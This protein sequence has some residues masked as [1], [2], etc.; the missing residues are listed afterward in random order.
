MHGL[1]GVCRLIRW[2]EKSE[3][4]LCM[5]SRISAFQ[6][7]RWKLS[8]QY[9]AV[10]VSALFVVVLVLG[11]MLVSRV[12]LPLDL[13][14]T[15]LS[16]TAWI[17]IVRND[18]PELLRHI[19]SQ[20]PIDTV[21]ISRFLEEGE[22][23]ITLSD[24]L[25]VGD[26][27][28]QLRTVGQGSSLL[29]DSKGILLGTSNPDI[30]SPN[31]VGEPI[32]PSILPGLEGPL[33]AALRGDLDVDRLFVTLVPDEEF[34]FAVPIHDESGQEVLG[35]VV[36]YIERLPTEN[37]Y[38]SNTLAL[39]GRSALVLLFSTGLAGM[40]F[41]FLTAKGITR[42][43]QHAS[44][45]TDAWSRGDFSTF[46][47]DTVNDEIGNLG[48]RLNRM[49]LQLKELLK[50][51]E[52]IAVIEERN[53]LARDL[54]D[55]AKQQALAA[56]FQIGTALTLYERE[57]ETAK[58]HLE[59]A[60]RLVDRVREEL[61]DLIMELRPQALEQRSIEEILSEYLTDWST[62]HAFE[63]EQALQRDIP[64]SVNAKQTLLRILQEALANIARHSEGSQVSIKLHAQGDEVNLE[65]K[66]NGVGFNPEKVTRGVGIQ[67][68]R[69][70]TESLGGSL[71][72]TSTPEQGTTLIAR[73]P[74]LDKR[75]GS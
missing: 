31:L 37:D 74:I 13:L 8:L 67:S 18:Y 75:E 56:S 64:L 60:E 19:L 14:D 4:G 45:V 48:E 58:S 30:V 61:T 38:V 21:L 35:V 24:L 53:R 46:I 2:F 52:E 42:R 55:S 65:V 12:M 27:E 20:D 43:L 57:P 40:F 23:Q 25:R 11:A 10:T 34:Y 47:A 22:L 28:V 5:R 50:R 6:T 33:E 16:P 54:H 1:A 3:M 15:S 49:A 66:D 71:E 59:E 73:I 72:L 63:L 70:R 69:E 68:M 41:G 39:A 26:I 29:L 62:Q 7:L 44:E 36:I 32:D 17:Q 9:S 51:R